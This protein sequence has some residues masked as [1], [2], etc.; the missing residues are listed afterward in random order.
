MSSNFYN[1]ANFT[2]DQNL[3]VVYGYGKPAILEILDTA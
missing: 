1:P 2:G 3:L